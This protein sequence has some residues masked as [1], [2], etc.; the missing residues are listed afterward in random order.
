LTD[1]CCAKTAGLIWRFRS[2]WSLV[3]PI[4]KSEAK[5]FEAFSWDNILNRLIGPVREN[6]QVGLSD[7]FSR[8]GLSA[9]AVGE[10]LL[11]ALVRASKVYFYI[12]R[13]SF[14]MLKF[15]GQLKQFRQTTSFSDVQR[16]KIQVCKHHRHGWLSP[17]GHSM[18]RAI[19]LMTLLRTPWTIQ[20]REES[21]T[22]THVH[23]NEQATIEFRREGMVGSRAR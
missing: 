23:M 18:L 22:H 14:Q 20:Q 16:A 11:A 17:S 9:Y 15:K 13:F 1:C 2:T 7:R 5:A 19:L 8:L 3:E 6:S 12:Q 10:A 4:P 21:N